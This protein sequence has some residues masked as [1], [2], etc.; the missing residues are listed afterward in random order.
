MKKAAAGAVSL[1]LLLPY[2]KCHTLYDRQQLPFFPIFCYNIHRNN[3]TDLI[4]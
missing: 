3:K 1:P 2:Y 4:S